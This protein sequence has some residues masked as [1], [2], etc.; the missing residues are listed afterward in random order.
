MICLYKD[1]YTPYLPQRFFCPFFAAKKW[2]PVWRTQNKYIANN[3]ACTALQKKTP[4]IKE[5][6]IT[7][8]IYLQIGNG[9]EVISVP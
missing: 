2:T 3:H 9:F 4:D 8:D 6:G 5:V 7:K 1:D